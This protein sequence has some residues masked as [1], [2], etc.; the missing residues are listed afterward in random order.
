MPKLN[1]ATMENVNVGHFGFS[2]VRN[3][4]LGASEYTLATI[5]VDASGS[6]G[7]FQAELEKCLQEVIKALQYSPRAD[8]LMV[9]LIKFASKHEEVHGF[10]LLENCQLNDYANILHCGGSTACFDSCIDAIEGIKNYATQ[11]N[12]N[13]ID[14]NG[15]VI[16]ITDGEDNVSKFGAQAVGS[17]KEACL[18]EE[19]LE[20]ILTVLIGVNAASL[21]KYLTSFETDGKFDQ[22]VLLKDASASTLAKLNG[23]ISKSISSQ[24]QSLGTGGPSQ[25]INPASMSLTI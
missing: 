18:K 17:A 3:D 9:R 14:V 11:L 6:V 25:V 7:N 10:K 23:F 21:T 2:A 5:V 22:K 20:S 12:S 8:N 16:V 1:D 19:A 24:S 4:Q 15:I 13:D